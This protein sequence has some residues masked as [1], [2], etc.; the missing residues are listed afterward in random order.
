MK[1]LIERLKVLEDGT[2]AT[3]KRGEIMEIISTLEAQAEDIHRYKVSYVEKELL[4]AKLLEATTKLARQEKL[5]E[6]AKG[7]VPEFLDCDGE[8]PCPGCVSR[9]NEWLAA[10]DEEWKK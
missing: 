1:S 10:L 8:K 9:A 3:L 2:Y 7:L 5:L 6:G 4:A